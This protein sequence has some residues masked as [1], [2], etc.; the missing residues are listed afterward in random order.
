MADTNGRAN[1]IGIY[2]VAF[3]LLLNLFRTQLG[4]DPNATAQAMRVE[5]LERTV[6]LI[7][8]DYARKDLVESQFNSIDYRLRVIDGQLDKANS[9][10][11]QIKRQR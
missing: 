4:L 2:S 7:Q 3:L 10:L 9:L 11:D 8:A 1:K 6:Q 5:T